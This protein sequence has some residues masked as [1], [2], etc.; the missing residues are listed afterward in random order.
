MHRVNKLSKEQM[1]QWIVENNATITRGPYIV[2]TRLDG[3]TFKCN[4]TLSAG[5]TQYGAAE[6][7]E[8]AIQE[9]YYSQIMELQ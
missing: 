1:F 3:T 9:A 7:L 5:G 2:W 8:E 6:T 4:F